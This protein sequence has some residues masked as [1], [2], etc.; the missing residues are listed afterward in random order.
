VGMLELHDSQ[1]RLA[2]WR[3]TLG[4]NPTALRVLE[5]F[6]NRWATIRGSAATPQDLPVVT[7]PPASTPYP[8]PPSTWALLRLW[9]FARPYRRPLAIG[10]ILTL[11]STA[12]ALVA[13]YLT[14]PL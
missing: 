9:R 8:S 14:M 2:V 6:Q 5:Q 7:P 4:R 3:Y 1:A 11:A 12:A 10:F 13:P